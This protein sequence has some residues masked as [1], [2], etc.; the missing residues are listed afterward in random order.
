MEGYDNN[1]VDVTEI[2]N[3]LHVYILPVYNVDG[4]E[5][6]WTGVSSFLI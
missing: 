3:E 2:L 5:F 6:T 4:Y 1:D